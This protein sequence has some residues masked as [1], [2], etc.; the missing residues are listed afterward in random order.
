MN[1]KCLFGG[2]QWRGYKCERCGERKPQIY[3]CCKCGAEYD[4]TGFHVITL[5]PCSRCGGKLYEK[6]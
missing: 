1:W 5:D 4:L 6:E 2:H 3:K